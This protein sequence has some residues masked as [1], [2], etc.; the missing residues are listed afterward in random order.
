MIRRVAEEA[1]SPL[2]FFSVWY[3]FSYYVGDANSFLTWL[4]RGG[5]YVLRQVKTT[6]FRQGSWYQKGPSV[7][8][9]YTIK[10]KKLKINLKLCTRILKSA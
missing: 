9:D 2:F 7:N 5:I 1:S 10:F 3:V 8:Y 4:Y 6:L